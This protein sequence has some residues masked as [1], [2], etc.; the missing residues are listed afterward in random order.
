LPIAPRQNLTLREQASNTFS[1]APTPSFAQLPAGTGYPEFDDQGKIV[2]K[3]TMTFCLEVD[4]ANLDSQ[5]EPRSEPV[6]L[7]WAS[8]K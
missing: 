2:S 5:G 3:T 6:S 8:G 4:K 1:G 7:T